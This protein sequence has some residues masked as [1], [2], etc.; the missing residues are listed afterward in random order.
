[1]TNRNN[2]N[3]KKVNRAKTIRDKKKA[4]INKK[5]SHLG[6]KE[7]IVEEPLTKKQLKK[8]KRLDQIYKELNVKYEDVFSKNKK[9]R[10]KNQQKTKKTAQEMQVEQ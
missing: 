9:R 2:F 10:K 6:F 1:M 5:K 8:Q 3:R 4:R 7:N